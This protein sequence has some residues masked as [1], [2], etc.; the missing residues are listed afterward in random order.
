VQIVVGTYHLGLGGIESYTLTVAEQL[1]RLGHDVTV[2]YVELGPGLELGQDRGLQVRQR[3]D[4]LPATC[5]VVFAQDAITAYQLADRYP[6]TPQVM[7]VH[8]DE[9]DFTT[10]PQLSGV[11]TAVVVLNDRVQRQVRALGHIPEIVRLRQ[12]VD[13]K[14]FYP[15]TGLSAPAKRALLLG[16]YVDHDRRDL[17]FRACAEA[18]IEVRQLGATSGRWASQPE[19]ELCTADIVFG[20]ARVIVEAMAC[21]RAAYVYDHNGGDGWVTN[22]RYEVLERDNFGGQAEPTVTD[23]ARLSADLA[24]Y[25][26]ELGQ[27][28]RDLA[29]ANHS[30]SRHG[31]ELVDLFSRVAAAPRE[32]SEAPLREMSRLTRLQWASE[33]RATG[34]AAEVLRL[35]AELE[36]TNAALADGHARPV[37]RGMRAFARRL[38]AGKARARL[39]ELK[40]SKPSKDRRAHSV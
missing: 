11:V 10:P 31:Q 18:G 9:Y 26:P 38:G 15:R 39:L 33:A 17:L 20:K 7:A 28:N 2:F 27:A 40:S 16:N 4:E 8:A 35:R 36:R 24:A 29:V 25:T 21:G 13:T 6:S 1:Q 3:E 37:R 19:L 12:P 14:R 5:D 32:R 34:F 22:E 23:L 30:A